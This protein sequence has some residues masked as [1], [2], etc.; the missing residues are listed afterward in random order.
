MDDG[1]YILFSENCYYDMWCLLKSI[2][3]DTPREI[4]S[5]ENGVF[6]LN[7]SNY[8]SDHHLKLSIKFLSDVITENLLKVGVPISNMKI[9]TILY[10]ILRYDPQ[11][12]RLYSMMII[13]KDE[14]LQNPVN[15]EEQSS[16][17]T[18]IIRFSMDPEK[19]FIKIIRFKCALS[20]NDIQQIEIHTEFAR[21]GI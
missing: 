15:S 1:D 17:Q 2:P 14:V 9:Y 19:Y 7:E 6:S 12:D 11:R 3:T 10:M 8:T 21:L 16:S 13:P 4:I 18:V 5:E 20:A